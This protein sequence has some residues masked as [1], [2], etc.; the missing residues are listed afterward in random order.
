MFS[1]GAPNLLDGEVIRFQQGAR[2]MEVNLES[3]RPAFPQ[4]TFEWTKD[5][6]A[7]S[8]SSGRVFGYP[9]LNI[10]TVDRSDSGLYTLAAR[11]TILEEPFDEIGNDTGSFTLDVVC[12][13]PEYCGSYVKL[14]SLSHSV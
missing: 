12:K 7:I 6:Q 1:L 14:D 11:N 8:N 13:L 4:P 2:N 9:A 5:G 3:G 10:D